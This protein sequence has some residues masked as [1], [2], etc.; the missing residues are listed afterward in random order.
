MR[1]W[2]AKPLYEMLPWFYAAAGALLLLA[3]LDSGRGV[4]PAVLLVL[5][6]ALVTAGSFIG[7]RRRD[8][9]RRH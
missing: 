2:L 8:Y 7:W 6:L 1:L 3:A 9:R 5:G 4:L